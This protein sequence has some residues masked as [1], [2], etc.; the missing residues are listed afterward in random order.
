MTEYKAAIIDDEPG[1]I[2]TL[3]EII[4]EYCPRLQITGTAPDPVKGYDLIKLQKP[5]IVFLDIEMP[6]G[7][8]FSLLDK[9]APVHFE[10]IF[11]SAF[12]NY[13]IRAIKYAALDY[14]LKPVNITEL[15]SAVT[16]AILRLEEKTS[17][18]RVDSL[19]SNFSKT[20]SE[21]HKIGLPTHDG[22]VFLKVSEIMYI[23]S[24]GNYTYLT[25]SD[26]KKMLIQKSLKEFGEILPQ[27]LFCRIHNSF[28][29][30][31]NRVK[32]YSRGR[33]GC[34]EMEDGAIIE[35]AV[36]KRDDFF[37]KFI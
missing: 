9:L 27:E 4:T 3:S 21:S 8:A 37:D 2:A 19:L 24:E 6:F 16:K 31:I 23:K 12:D 36:R 34:V 33:G 14:I 5:D 30:N 1:N 15:K 11:V 17:N 25:K 32:K 22:V 13:A 7:N 10:V 20:N 35:V 18:A 28:I 26:N 29:I